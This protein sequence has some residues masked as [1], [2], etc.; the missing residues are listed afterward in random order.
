MPKLTIPDGDMQVDERVDFSSVSTGSET[1]STGSLTPSSFEDQAVIELVI[2]DADLSICPKPM[3]VH[4]G[5]KHISLGDLHGN[6]MK[7]IYT[8]IEEGFLD[9]GEREYGV[10]NAIYNK[11][12]QMLYV[13]DLDYFK[14]ILHRAKVNNDKAL[15]LIGDELADRGKNDFWMLLVLK[16]LHEAQ[17]DIDVLLSNHNVDF[18]NRRSGGKGIIMDFQTP[19]YHNMEV[20][21]ANGIIS[22]LEVQEI[23]NLHY[24]PIVKALRYSISEK[25]E[26]TIYTH[27]PVGL[28][29]VEALALKLGV[30]YDEKTSYSVM[31]TI[32]NINKKI[33]ELFATGHMTPMLIEEGLAT[34]LLMGKKIPMPIASPFMRLIWNRHLGPELRMKSKNGAFEITDVHGHVGRGS[35]KKEDGALSPNHQNTDNN[36]GKEAA[37]I[38]AKMGSR[39]EHFT[40]RS[41][42]SPVD[43]IKYQLYTMMAEIKSLTMEA[44]IAA[45]LI[46]QELLISGTTDKVGLLA[47]KTSLE[48]LLGELVFS[49][50]RAKGCAKTIEASEPVFVGAAVCGARFFKKARLETPAPAVE[51]SETASAAVQCAT[52]V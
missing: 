14:A 27:A 51:L 42:D 46:S 19:S 13:G 16:R 23:I 38:H 36:F 3:L 21:I 22:D 31:R 47:I 7:F 52:V 18:L 9:I 41:P 48:G 50:S 20:L 28:E 45:F 39:V 24:L 35:V 17:V 44:G 26:L 43:A 12:P 33:S 15:T 6:V 5:H 11:E 29:T 40:R 8:L 25:G 32:D 2:R 1:P 34:V 30:D 4:K 37:I 49:D 10:L